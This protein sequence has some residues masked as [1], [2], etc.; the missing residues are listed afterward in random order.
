MNK[1]N[2]SVGILY[3]NGIIQSYLSEKKS[4]VFCMKMALFKVIYRKKRQQYHCGYDSL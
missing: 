4:A 1:H 3:E 2:S